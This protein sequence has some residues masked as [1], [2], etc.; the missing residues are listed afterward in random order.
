MVNIDEY[1]DRNL[2]TTN[3]F[4]TKFKV[5]GEF[6]ILQGKNRYYFKPT[7]D[8]IKYVE[9]NKHSMAA[10]HPGIF[11]YSIDR[12]N[13]SFIF[14]LY[15]SV[16]IKEKSIIIK[17]SYKTKIYLSVEEDKLIINTKEE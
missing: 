15:T 13:D 2:F 6:L 11:I 9:F 12:N 16:E 17:M 1:L 14:E 5:H 7:D 4:R 8:T 10:D 3:L